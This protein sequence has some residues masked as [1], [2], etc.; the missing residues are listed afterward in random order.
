ML[1]PRSSENWELAPEIWGIR[2]FG[3]VHS[4]PGRYVDVWSS[5]TVAEELGT[6]FWDYGGTLQKKMEPLTHLGISY[7]LGH[8]NWAWLPSWPTYVE[9]FRWADTKKKGMWT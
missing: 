4:H 9:L 8:C 6:L 7:P 5:T 3:V 2:V 1:L